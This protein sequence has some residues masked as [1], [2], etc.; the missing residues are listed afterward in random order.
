MWIPSQTS[1]ELLSHFISSVFGWFVASSNCNSTSVL[2]L[3]ICS[4]LGSWIHRI[5]VVVA[6][7]GSGSVASG[8]SN[9]LFT[10]ET[11]PAFALPLLLLPL[12]PFSLCPL[13]F[14]H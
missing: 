5:V 8:V 11:C 10:V 7:A 3:R 1:A 12:L 13:P 4:I 2:S 6:V 14:A 9:S